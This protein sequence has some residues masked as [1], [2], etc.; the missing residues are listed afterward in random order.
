M[1]TVSVLVCL[2]IYSFVIEAGKADGAGS[3]AHFACTVLVLIYA[4][5][6]FGLVYG[7][8]LTAIAVVSSSYIVSA[9]KLAFNNVYNLFARAFGAEPELA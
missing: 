4:L 3:K 7:L 1:F 2:S 5:L 6:G 8:A 9:M